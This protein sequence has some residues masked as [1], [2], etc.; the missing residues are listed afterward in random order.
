MA[1]TLRCPNMEFGYNAGQFYCF[2]L[3]H[4]YVNSAI[5]THTI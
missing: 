3:S 4:F 2:E 1:Q 5:K